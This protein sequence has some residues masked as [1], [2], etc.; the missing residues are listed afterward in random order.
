[1]PGMMIS[2]DGMTL[3]VHLLLLFVASDGAAAIAEAEAI[4]DRRRRR[5][6]QL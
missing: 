4:R 2:T 3:A 5:Y 6:R 1:M